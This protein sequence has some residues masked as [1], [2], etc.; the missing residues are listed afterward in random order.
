MGQESGKVKILYLNRGCMIFLF[1]EGPFAGQTIR[2]HGEI[3]DNGYFCFNP[4][5]AEQIYSVSSEQLRDIFQRGIEVIRKLDKDEY[6]TLIQEIKENC[7]YTT[8][9]KGFEFD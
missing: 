9:C 5:C 7:D 6:P 8:H 4:F 2:W 1:E 3:L